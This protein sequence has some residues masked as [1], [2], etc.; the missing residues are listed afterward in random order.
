MESLENNYTNAL[1]YRLDK[2]LLRRR[3]IICNVSMLISDLLIT[4]IN[5]KN[6]IILINLLVF[7][8]YPHL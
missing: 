3:R 2:D 8:S 7:S 6:G 4:K 1:P 5:A